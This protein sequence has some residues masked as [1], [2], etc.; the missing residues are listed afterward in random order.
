MTV[1]KISDERLVAEFM[2]WDPLYSDY[3]SMWN[4]LMQIVLEIDSLGYEVHIHSTGECFIHKKG[5]LH[6][7]APLRKCESLKESV[8]SACVDFVKW[9]D[10]QEK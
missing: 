6:N 2:G 10:Q 8:F 1:K 3:N 9:Y 4:D 7:V 5:T